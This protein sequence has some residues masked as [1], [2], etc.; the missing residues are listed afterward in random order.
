LTIRY[1]PRINYPS[2]ALQRQEELYNQWAEQVKLATNGFSQLRDARKTIE[3]VRTNA[4]VLGE[5][6]KKNMLTQCDSLVQK[7]NNLEGEFMLSEDARGI[8]DDSNLLN[9][10][11]WKT[12]SLINT[13]DL[14]PAANAASA[15]QALSVKNRAIADRVNAFFDTDWAVFQKLVDST[16]MPVFQERRRL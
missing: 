13:G 14:M 2:D 8:Q 9:S 15:L 10:V 5:K 16:S 12:I 6:D 4:D 1:D 11:L 3:R 7:I